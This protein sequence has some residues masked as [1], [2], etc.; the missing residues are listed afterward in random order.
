MDEEW[1]EGIESERLHGFAGFYPGQNN[2]QETLSI[3]PAA[4]SRQ[5]T[6]IMFKICE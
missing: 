3:V 5:Q 1:A 2:K 4:P 6:A